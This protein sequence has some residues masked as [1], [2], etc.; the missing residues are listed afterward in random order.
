MTT[1]EKITQWERI[2]ARG[3]GRF[4]FVYGVLAWGIPF[5]LIFPVLFAAAMGELRQIARIYS[6]TFPL[7]LVG[8]FIFG[9]LMWLVAERN[10]RRMLRDLNLTPPGGTN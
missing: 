1:A 5:G 8:G 2:R 3:V 10:Y 9:L 4:I 7:A 6:L